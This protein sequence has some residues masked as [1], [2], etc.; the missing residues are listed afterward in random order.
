MSDIENIQNS[1]ATGEIVIYQPDDTIRI[2]VKVE[3]ETVW[4]TQAQMAELFQTTRNNVTIHISNIFKE[5]ELEKVEVCKDFLHTTQH[6]AIS[7]KTQKKYV[8][9][10]N[11]DVII[12]VGYRIKSKRGT[13]FRRWATKVLKEYMLKG[14]VLNQRIERVESIAIETQQRVTENEK[15][16]HFLA[17]YIEEIIADNNDINEDTRMQ[18]ENICEVLAELQ[19]KNKLLNKPI[20]PVGFKISEK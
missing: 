2:E 6:G 12:S 16:I 20:N 17:R 11:L 5:G 3:D 10:Y 18:L 15:K 4:L 13:A 19:A 7:G 8:T 14:F 1:Q 9:S